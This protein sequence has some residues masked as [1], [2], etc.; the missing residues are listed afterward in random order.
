MVS[1]IVVVGSAN[2]NFVLSMP[3][4]PSKGETVLGG[5]FRMARGCKG[6]KPAAAAAHLGTVTHLGAQ[7]S[8]PIRQKH[9]QFM[10]SSAP[11]R[12]PAVPAAVESTNSEEILS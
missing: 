4:L 2:T 7:P 12:N 5:Q 9:D 3:E 10:V 8:F 1:K 11:G 6:A